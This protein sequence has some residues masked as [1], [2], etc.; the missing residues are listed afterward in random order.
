MAARSYLSAFWSDR[1]GA[2][3]IEYA[4]LISILGMGIA[5]AGGILGQQIYAKI[6][7][8][9]NDVNNAG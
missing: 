8:V 2:T 3:A 1:R 7:S 9:V 4:L 5:V 6:L